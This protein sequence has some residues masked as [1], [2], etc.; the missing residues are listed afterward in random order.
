MRKLNFL[1]LF[2]L[3]FAAIS[4]LEKIKPGMSFEEVKKNFPNIKSDV[5]AM[6]SWVTEKDS[7]EGIKGFTEYVI[8]QDTL[9]RYEYTSNGFSGPCKNFP[10]ADSLNYIK[11]ISVAN[12]LYKQYVLLYGN[13]AEHYTISEL[14]DDTSQTPVSVLYAKWKHGNN[15]LSISVTRP[16]KNRRPLM[17][18]PPPTE[19]EIK[20]GCMY[21]LEVLS[22]GS[23]NYF[24]KTV[25]NGMTGQEFK[26]HHPTLAYEV[27]NHPNSWMAED[28]FTYNHGSWRFH[29]EGGKLD[30]YS[31]DVYDGAGYLH[32]ADSAYSLLKNITLI[33]YSEALKLHGKP[34]TLVNKIL[35]RYPGKGSW[36]YH[37]TIHF[38]SEWKY[39]DKK[40]YIIF[41]ESSGGKQFNPILHLMVYYGLPITRK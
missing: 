36:L 34:E 31:L 18:E 32:N 21:S 17:N 24:R 39:L 30:S 10:H 2:F 12:K 28:T 35:A 7:M 11:L 19:E 5:S 33:L 38:E 29:F 14:A 1:L 41:D 40:L 26:Q 25:E 22:I 15:E 37:H 8:S 16:G 27:E 13:P 23:G 4:Q 9:L 6:S 3:P 20:P